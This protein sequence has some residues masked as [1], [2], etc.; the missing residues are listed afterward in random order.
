MHEDRRHLARAADVSTSPSGQAAPLLEVED[1][2]KTYGGNLGRFGA[3]LA[4]DR[5][6]AL[7]GVSLS[8]LPGESLGI[9]GE[10]G[11][12]KTTL[13][14]CIAG[15]VTPT[16]G[17][18]R[19]SGRAAGEMPL[20]RVVQMVFQDPDSS[21]NPGRK[22]GSVLTEI[23]RVHRLRPRPEISGRVSE[24]LGLV[25]LPASVAQSYPRHLSGGQRQRV[26]IARALAFEPELVIADEVVSALDVSV[27]A[28]ILNLLADLREATGLAMIVVSHNLA[29]VR[30]LCRQLLVMNQ[31]EVV[32]RG[33]VQ[34]VLKAPE[35][36]YT[37]ELV[38]AVL[39]VDPP[40][41]AAQNHG[42][43]E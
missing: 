42:I 9:V 34:R 10:T 2:T 3:G 16:S 22:V 40:Q 4:A 27:Q 36:P 23:L 6:P 25:G 1:V 15:L 30:Y 20:H 7:K 37:R 18:I 31:G 24:L 13:G 21:L 35:H 12:G 43:Q 32:E 38:R 33:E 39:T 14:N 11:S 8:L 26:A 19:F 5:T 41:A 28:Q 29:V 17:S